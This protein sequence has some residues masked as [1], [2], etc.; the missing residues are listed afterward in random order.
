[1]SKLTAEERAL[2]LKAKKT[3]K[4]AYRKAK[5]T[6]P[7]VKG[8]QLPGGIINGVSRFTDYKFAA[9]KNGNPYLILTGI[10]LVPEEHAGARAQ[11]SFFLAPPKSDKAKTLEEKYEDLFSDLQLLGVDTTAFDPNSCLEEMLE[12]LKALVKEKPCFK[13]NTW[14]KD[15]ESDT[16]VF[17]QGLADD[18]DE[19]EDDEEEWEEDDEEESDE[20]SEEEE[21]EEES[22]EE[23]YEE[24]EEVSDESEDDEEEE[25]ESDDEESEEEEEEEEDESDWEPS[26]GDIYG[27]AVNASAEPFDCEVTTVSTTKQTV[28]LKRIKDGKVF[29][30]VSWEKLTDASEE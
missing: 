12:S 1:M 30:T 13:F 11:R 23:E 17:I 9:D 5:D 3:S 2:I 10:V 15:K 28:T 19:G 22:D 16:V 4:G 18:P 29:K 7:K 20:E 21:S 8:Q 25:E 24:E 27:Y 26:V 14:K 6:E